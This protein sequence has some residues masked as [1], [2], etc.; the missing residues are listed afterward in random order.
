M[1]YEQLISAY[2]DLLDLSQSPQIVQIL[3]RVIQE[4]KPMYLA[5]R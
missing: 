5:E 2:F 4:H 3:S 1:N